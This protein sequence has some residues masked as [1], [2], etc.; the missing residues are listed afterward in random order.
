MT[1]GITV[2]LADPVP[3]YEQIRR[4]LSSL[5]AVGVLE[6]GSRLPTVRSLAADLGIAA[7]TVARAYK[8]LEQS[9]LIESRRRNG[10]VVVGPPHAPDGAVRADAA[11]IS[12]VDG[13][14]RTARAAGIGD[15]TLIDLL[16]GRLASKLEE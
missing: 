13:L 11:V 16:R 6:P 9:G 1:A 10:T 3:P 14:I 8:E 4:Q 2:D 15:D 12:A 7:G 5:I